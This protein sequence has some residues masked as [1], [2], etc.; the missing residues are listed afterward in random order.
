MAKGSAPGERRGGRQKGTPNRATAD[1]KALAQQYTGEAI[2]TLAEIM[3]TSEN[4]T[5][6][7]A[8]SKELIDRGHGKSVQGVELTGKDG[9][10]IVVAASPLDERL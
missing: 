8:A 10:A 5:A 1:I 3:R 9:G 6:R 2:K 4:D 7:I